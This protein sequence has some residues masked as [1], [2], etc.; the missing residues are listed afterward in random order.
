MVP[1]VE[2][3]VVRQHVLYTDCMTM[4]DDP[5]PVRRP[6]SGSGRER[7][8]EHLRSR[9]LSVPRFQ[10][11]F[12]NEQQVADEIGVS[13]TPVREALLILAS[14]G[15]VDMLPNR[16]AY[17]APLSAREITEIMELRGLLERHSVRRALAAHAHPERGMKPILA[18]QRR[19]VRSRGEDR[20]RDFIELDRQFHQVLVDAA[21]NAV[22]S[23]TYAGLRERQVR[24]GIAALGSSARLTQVC[25]E[26]GQILA[27]LAAEDPERAGRAIDDHLQI[28]LDSL[29]AV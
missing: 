2:H 17:V 10:G 15:L 25:S 18:A 19:L 20:A 26:H 3:V 9:I 22:L 8:L 28:T 1:S 13:R 27:A 12:V 7:A 21:G 6:A 29:L 16:G 23:R 5:N 11:T 4:V 14:E 24:I